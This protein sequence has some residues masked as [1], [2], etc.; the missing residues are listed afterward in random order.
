MP[1]GLSTLQLSID[2]DPEYHEL[3]ISELLDFGFESFEQTDGKLLAYMQAAEASPNLET[4][5]S[6]W[7]ESRGASTDFRSTIIPHENWNSAWEASIQPI[8]VGEFRIVS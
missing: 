1:A 7:L 2:L 4:F 6:Q 8:E 3:L 5:L